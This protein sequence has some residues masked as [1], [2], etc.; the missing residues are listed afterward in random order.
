MFV[1]G[2]DSIAIGAIGEV[3]LVRVDNVSVL[4]EVLVG[5]SRGKVHSF[6]LR[7]PGSIATR[8]GDFYFAIFSF[9]FLAW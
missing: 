6:R 1:L 9:S 7:S 2:D 8:A 5:I 3:G 4:R